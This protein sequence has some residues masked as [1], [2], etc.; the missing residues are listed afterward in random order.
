MIDYYEEE[1][2][3]KKIIITFVVI[4]VAFVVC[5]ILFKNYQKKYTLTIKPKLQFEVGSKVSYD[6]KKYVDNEILDKKDY[7]IYFDTI[8][9]DEEKGVFTTTGDY[10][11]KIV[12]KNIKKTGKLKIIDTVGPTVQVKD[13]TV[14]LNENFTPAL[15]VTSCEDYSMPC[16]VQYKNQ[17]DASLNKKAGNYTVTV[18]ISDTHGNKTYKTVR[19]EVK[20]GYSLEA[21]MQKDLEVAS[22]D[23]DYGDFEGQYFIKYTKGY[24]EEDVVLTDEYEDLLETMDGGWRRFLPTMYQYNRIDKVDV[25]SVYNKWGYI[26]GFA[27]R[28]ELDNGKGIYV[29]K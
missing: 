26:I 6:I 13:L 23:T 20:K 22:L 15:F 19:L 12:Y 24:D 27:V 11:F 21:E 3:Y 17:S 1:V 7:S 8:P 16:D 5:F 9:I 2:N 4:V 28:L 14:G 25:I 10:T 29:T 18:S